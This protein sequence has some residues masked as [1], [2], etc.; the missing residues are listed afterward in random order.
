MEASL[1]G[2]VDPSD[3][4][5]D[6]GFEQRDQRGVVCLR[7]EA[8][9][10]PWFTAS[11]PHPRILELHYQNHPHLILD[12]VHHNNPQR[13]LTQEADWRPIEDR[14][15]IKLRGA[16]LSSL[17]RTWTYGVPLPPAGPPGFK[18][19][20]PVVDEPA[21]GKKEVP[22]PD[23]I[24]LVVNDCPIIELLVND[25]DKILSRYRLTGFFNDRKP[26]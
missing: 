15:H 9:S 24:P 21:V 7:A 25:V 4:D 2:G 23:L 17:P 11:P 18:L 26:L 13:D 20:E 6:G 12:L 5:A 19:E 10:G 3:E 16:N 22:N 14:S 1:E 8:I